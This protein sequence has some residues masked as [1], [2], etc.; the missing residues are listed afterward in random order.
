MGDFLMGKDTQTQQI[1]P[2]L[3][4]ESQSL[5][6]LFRSLAERPD[7]INRGPTIAAFTPDQEAAFG[8]TDSA[9]KAFGMGV[10]DRTSMPEPMT[11]AQGIKGYSIAPEYDESMAS[12]SPEYKQWREA[13]GE[14][15]S[16]PTPT[17]SFDSG[18]KK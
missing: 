11:S 18:G 5:I 2:M 3:A 6:N 17:Q 9:A 12:L 15:A 10:A 14:V 13:F 8:A 1:D 4:A 7:E 16:T